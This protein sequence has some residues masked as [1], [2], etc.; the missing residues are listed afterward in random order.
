M[1]ILAGSSR[2][3]AVLW[4]RPFQP[5]RALGRP[6]QAGAARAAGCRPQAAGAGARR[7]RVGGGPRSSRALTL[8]AA[9]PPGPARHGQWPEQGVRTGFGSEASDGPRNRVPT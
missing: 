5:S 1:R 2:L 7:P 9:R 4:H 8:P 6:G 3:A